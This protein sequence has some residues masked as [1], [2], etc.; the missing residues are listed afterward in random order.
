MRRWSSRAPSPTSTRPWPRLSTP[1]PGFS[2]Q[3]TLSV[4]I[5]DL[6]NTGGAAQVT[7]DSV[8]ISVVDAT[9][10]A[11]TVTN[12]GAQNVDED[13]DLTITGLS[14]GDI[15]AGSGNLEVTLSVTD[16]LL[17][18][19]DTTGLTF[20][21]GDG[22][23]NS[24][25]TFRGNLDDIN[26]AIDGLIYRGDLNFNGSDTLQITVNYLGNSVSNLRR[27]DPPPSTT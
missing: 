27:Y 26:A 6:G 7:S 11:P 21:T 15:D 13:T 20:T 17:T 10:T 9:N 2:G 23:Q 5:D 19:P 14:I 1:R 3:D 18:L 4:S 12:S 25:L 22:T 16:G 8:L 24:T